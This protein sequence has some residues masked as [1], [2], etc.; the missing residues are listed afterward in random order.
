MI[1]CLK[2]HQSFQQQ[3]RA[4]A[5]LTCWRA[6]M[7]GA[8]TF[9]TR[10]THTT[11]SALWRLVLLLYTQARLWDHSKNSLDRLWCPVNHVLLTFTTKQRGKNIHLVDY[12]LVPMLCTMGLVFSNDGLLFLRYFFLTSVMKVVIN[13]LIAGNDVASKGQVSWDIIE[14]SW[15]H[16]IVWWVFIRRRGEAHTVDIFSWCILHLWRDIFCHFPLCNPWRH[17][18]NGKRLQLKVK[19]QQQL[20]LETFWWHQSIQMCQWS[21]NYNNCR[22]DNSLIE[23]VTFSLN[24]PI[25]LDMFWDS[26][27]VWTKESI[28]CHEQTTLNSGAVCLDWLWW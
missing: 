15:T 26:L 13:K 21:R 6:K 20:L 24:D 5:R 19:Q 8:G 1:L 4:A 10:H 27:V 22:N 14:C 12:N 11:A 25:L 28:T 17:P 9:E 7:F 3:P 23:D 2:T 18:N 16:F